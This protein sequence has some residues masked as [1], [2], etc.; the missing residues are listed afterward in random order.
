MNKNWKDDPKKR[1]EVEKHIPLGYAADPEEIAP[2]VV[3][4]ASADAL[5]IT[6]VTLYVD[7]GDTLYP[8]YMKNFSS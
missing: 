6:G 7:G 3:F 8:S 2:A 4:L 1:A 5:Y